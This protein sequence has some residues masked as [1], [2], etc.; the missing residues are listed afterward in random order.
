MRTDTPIENNDVPA[1]DHS[2]LEVMSYDDCVRA[3]SAGVVG[4]VAFMSMGQPVILPVN[5]VWDDGR[6]VFRTAIGEK[7]DAAMKDAPVAFEIDEWDELYRV[8]WSV[9]VKGHLEEIF[10]LEDLV[11]ARKLG[12]RPYAQTVE[13]PYYIQIV[14]DEITGRR[15]A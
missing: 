14:P 15:I 9:V 4:R 8:G 12:V 13:R 5:Y 11:E 2:G 7:L 1:V 3:L 6:I 10:D